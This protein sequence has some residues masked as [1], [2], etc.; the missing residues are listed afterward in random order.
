MARVFIDAY[1]CVYC[2]GWYCYLL[3]ACVLVCVN[4]A[5]DWSDCGVL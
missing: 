2:Y 5:L 1:L 3:R 4:W